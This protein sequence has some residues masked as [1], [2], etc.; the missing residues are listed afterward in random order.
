MFSF[1]MMSLFS[2]LVRILSSSL[3]SNYARTAGAGGLGTGLR[4][5]L[6]RGGWGASEGF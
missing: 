1:S 3:S 5:V 4:E 6:V 2:T